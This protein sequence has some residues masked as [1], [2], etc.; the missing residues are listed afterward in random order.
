MKMD[1]W[2]MVIMSFM[3]NDILNTLIVDTQSGA[4]GNASILEE[5]ERALHACNS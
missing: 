5:L 1:F 2:V 3:A 4:M